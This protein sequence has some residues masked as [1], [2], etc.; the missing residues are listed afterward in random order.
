IA[1]YIAL[2]IAFL[3]LLRGVVGARDEVQRGIWFPGAPLPPTSDAPTPLGTT[4]SLEQYETDEELTRALEAAE[5]LG[6]GWLRQELPWDAIEPTR[7]EYEWEPWD[8]VIEAASE[9]GFRLILVLNR[10]PAWARARGEQNNP[11]APP[12]ETEDFLRFTRAAA[13][14][15]GKQ[16]LGWQ[17]WDEPNLM[18][19]WGTE[20]IIEPAQYAAFLAA[21]APVLRAADPG[22]I[23]ATAGLAPT[24]EP[25]GFNMSEF[26]FLQGLY[27]AG[28]AD[29][30]DVVALKPYGFWTGATQRLYGEKTMNFDRVVLV[31][32]V[33]ESQGDGATP[34][35]F[36]EGGWAV[37]PPD[38]QGSPPPWGSDVPAAQQPRLEAAI[39]RS[40]LEW[41]WVQLVALQ[42]LQ[43][44]V[45]PTDPRV[46]LALLDET[47]ELTV[48]GETTA[49][50][51]TLF[52]KGALGAEARA[53]WEQVERPA[54]HGYEWAMG[55]I[56]LALLGLSLR[57]GWHLWCLPWAAWGTW[58]RQQ[59]ELLQLL[60]LA[61]TALTL[62]AVDNRVGALLLYALLGVLIVW[63]LDLGL[64]LVAFS[65]PFFL[66]SKSFGPLSFSMV[67]LLLLLCAVG[68]VGNGKL[69]VK[70]QRAKGKSD[71]ERQGDGDAIVGANASPGWLAWAEARFWPRDGLDWAVLLFAVWGGVSLLFTQH[72]G[73]A[74]REFRVVVAE[75]VLWYWLLRRAPLT[76]EQHYRVVDALIV[77]ASVVAIYGLYQWLFTADIIQAE[78]VRRVRGVYGSPNNLALMLERV[79]P[80]VGAFLLLA[81]PSR[82]RIFYAGAVL[83]L[84]LC[85]FLT[86]SRGAWLL[87]MPAALL[88][89]AWWGGKRARQTV[90]V[91]GGVALLALIP[92]AATERIASTTNLEGGT[93]YIRFRLW[94]ATIAMLRDFPLLG[95]GLDNFLYV[96]E[97]YRLPEAWR[98]PDLS[99]PHQLLLH[100]WVALGVPGVILL[101][102]QQAAFWRHWFR[103]LARAHWGTMARAL[104]VGMG[105]SMIATLSHGMID[106]SFFLVDLAFIWM[107][108]LAITTLLPDEAE[109]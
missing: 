102:W 109:P 100:F 9:R 78:G 35:W 64:A 5:A 32:E 22:A 14:R 47:G 106:N 105:S 16:V 84:L 40:T 37:L 20:V 34:L 54:L 8:R 29:H 67:E 58:F 83:P 80:I 57:L 53:Q 42:P 30:F 52:F 81:P 56:A 25:G 51:G 94:E 21:T 33:M 12:A 18:P 86:F 97:H 103:T 107:M 82:R 63:R 46:G 60:A 15:Y 101:L 45:P 17:V 76:A 68:W 99:H 73:V 90:L 61:A 26:Y 13:E 72:F 48:L 44:N 62:Y 77:G 19:H 88:W 36:V 3:L 59:P 108:T 93:W 2:I 7:G 27:E 4:V 50:M 74:A 65:I 89:I 91:L 38:W 10:T 71:D 96:Y 85:L 1:F 75:S 95:V 11:L 69:K 98:E 66:K 49:K 43:P 92:F 41:P 87:G 70:S 31:R 104:L 23:V 39:R 6:I 24:G 55:F 79:L 28:A